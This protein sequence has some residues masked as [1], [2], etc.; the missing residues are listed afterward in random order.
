MGLVGKK[1]GE[2]RQGKEISIYTFTNEAGMS[3]DVTNAGGAIMAIRTPDRSGALADVTLGYDDPNAY[4]RKGPF[5]GVLVGRFAN[6]IGGAAFE[7]NGVEYKLAKNDGNNHLHGG[8]SGFDKQVWDATIDGDK[9][10]LTYTSADGEEGYPGTLTAK[11][12]YSLG[13]D[14]SLGIA[15]EASSDQDTL[16]NLTNHAYFNLAGHDSGDI[17]GHELMIN[18][19]A[20]TPMDAESIPTGEVRPVAGTPMDFSTLRPIGPGLARTDDEQI[21]NGGGYDHNWV[22]SVSG[23]E[24][25]KAAEVYEPTSGR[26][27]EVFTT[28]PGVQ[29]YSGNFLNGEPGKGGAAYGKRGGLCL[30]TQYYPDSVHHSNFPSAVLRA[31]ETYRHTTIYKFSAK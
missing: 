7:L 20:F 19:M 10:V 11:V 22:L 8:P 9:L 5:F 26:V 12:T 2:S 14:G 1:F 21:A 31:G 13:E 18:A 30:E 17:E 24:P 29:F 3:V 28:K 16:C 23:N 4:L 6:R 25:E 15:Y 27:M